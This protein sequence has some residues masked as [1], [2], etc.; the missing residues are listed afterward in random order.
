MDILRERATE[1]I[2]LCSLTTARVVR[3]MYPSTCP[4]SKNSIT[5]TEATT[6]Y[7]ERRKR[8]THVKPSHARPGRHKRGARQKGGTVASRPLA[9]RKKQDRRNV[10]LRLVFSFIDEQSYRWTNSFHQVSHQY[11]SRL[12]KHD[13]RVLALHTR[14]R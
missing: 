13:G 1:Q 7:V 4:N 8:A 2:R 14:T 5:G 10:H 11:A 3:A 9:T 6:N 12:L